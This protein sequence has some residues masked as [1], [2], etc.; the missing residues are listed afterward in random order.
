MDNSSAHLQTFLVTLGDAG[1]VVKTVES[2]FEVVS[3]VL[4]S[5][6][7]FTLYTASV[8]LDSRFG[9]AVVW[10]Q[11]PPCLTGES[12]TYSTTYSRVCVFEL[13]SVTYVYVCIVQAFSMR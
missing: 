8:A 13:E 3:T 6:T 2:G 10:V 4:D 7:P 11:C 5:L 9:E 12:G 1:A